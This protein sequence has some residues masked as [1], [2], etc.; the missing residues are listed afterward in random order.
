MLRFLILLLPTIILFYIDTTYAADKRYSI[1]S[2]Y[3]KLISQYPNITL[4]DLNLPENIKHNVGLPYKRISH[5]DLV[6]DIFSLKN[7]E[8]KQPLIMLIHG[9]GWKSGQISLMKPLAIG[10]AKHGY[11]V[12]TPSYSLS[13]EAKYPEAYYDLVDA[14]FWLKEHAQEY[15]I[16]KNKVV[17][18]GTSAGG[19]LAALLAYSGGRLIGN[20]FSIN[21]YKVQALLN[22][23]GLSNFTSPEALYYENDPNK[24]P[25]S[26]GAWFGGSYE[27]VPE[28]WRQASPSYYISNNAPPTLFL[29]S[30]KTRFHAG[31]DDA[32]KQLTQ[33]GIES[34]IVKLENSP[35]SFWLLNPWLAPS[36]KECVDFLENTLN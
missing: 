5:R 2:T 15:N 32:I 28:L 31:R 29:N 23:D 30:S 22:I 24:N 6:L 3:H 19:Q 21:E 10:L 1:I 12:A 7:L 34:K 17:L 13:G 27:I 35:H 14:L 25:S 9:G 11:I 33:F 16:D 26:A 18:A 36:I 4:P 20:S 8:K